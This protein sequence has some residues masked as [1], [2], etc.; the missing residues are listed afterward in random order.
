MKLLRHPVAGL[1]IFAVLTILLITIYDQGL[2]ENYGI[3]EGDLKP[4][5]FT[6][7]GEDKNIMEQFKEL[8]LIEGMSTVST[9]IS[10]LTPGSAS[11]IDILGGLAAVAVGALKTVVGAVTAIY[12]IP[13][14]ILGYYAGDIPGVIGGAIFSIFMIYVA[15]IL[16]SAYLRSDV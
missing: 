3:T 11:S 12:Q 7:G 13:R 16:L 6:S 10:E 2:V 1:V 15:F 8:N 9:G 5:N 14:I 4:T